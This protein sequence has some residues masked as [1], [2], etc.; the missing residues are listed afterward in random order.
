MK[1]IHLMFKFLWYSVCIWGVSCISPGT[2][3]KAQ[4]DIYM[5]Y[6][7]GKGVMK[8]EQRQRVLYRMLTMQIGMKHNRLYR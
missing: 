4:M 7:T 1:N 2:Y 8:V 5:Q 3:K 6:C